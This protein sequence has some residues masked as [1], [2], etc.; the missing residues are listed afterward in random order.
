M[1]CF[2]C[3]VSRRAYLLFTRAGSIYLYMYIMYA[4]AFPG[5]WVRFKWIYHKSVLVEVVEELERWL[6]NVEEVVVA[7]RLGD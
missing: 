2:F 4:S 7:P 5:L 1:L 3:H 6:V